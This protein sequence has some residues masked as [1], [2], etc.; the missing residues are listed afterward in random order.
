ELTRVHRPDGES[1]VEE[2]EGAAETVQ[3]HLD[4]VYAKL[5]AAAEETLE[6][7]VREADSR[8]EI[9]GTIGRHGGY[10][11]APW[12]GDEACESE[13]KDQIAAEIVMVPFEE[14]DALVG[15]DHDETCA[16]CGD[17]AERTA[18]FAKSY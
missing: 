9:L 8:D 6:E 10:V 11:K 1:S 18:Y 5:Y 4:E 17:G 15:G 2:R 16:V 12:C 13:I 3:R 7:G 14:E